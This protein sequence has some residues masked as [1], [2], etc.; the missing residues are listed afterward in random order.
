VRTHAPKHGSFIIQ[1][2]AYCGTSDDSRDA[3]GHDNSVTQAC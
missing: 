3:Q 1:M 2:A